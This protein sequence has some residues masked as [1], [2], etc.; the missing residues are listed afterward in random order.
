MD[1]TSFPQKQQLEFHSK[2]QQNL[3]G[4]LLFRSL[5]AFKGRNLS[6]ILAEKAA[7]GSVMQL[8]WYF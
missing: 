7:A 5:K 2:D 3:V 4:L 8:A 6:L 1:V